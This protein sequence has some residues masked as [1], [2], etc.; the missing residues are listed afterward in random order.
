M[1]RILIIALSGIGDAL[2][3]TPALKLL[4]ES[5]PD[6]KI[7]AL[8][9][10]KG[11]KEM[12]ERNPHLDNV[13]YFDFINSG[14]YASLKFVLSL[15]LKYDAA[16]NVY[17]SNRKEY[18]VISFLT[19][20]RNRVAA[21]YLRKDFQNLGFLNNLRTVEDDS[22]HN[23]LTNVMLVESLLNKKFNEK[24][25]LDFPV[26]TEDENYAAKF[27]DDIN[28]KGNDIVIGFHPGSA[29]LKNHIHRR[30][31][32]EKFAEL[33]KRLINEF[34]ASVFIFGGPEEDELKLSIKKMIGLPLAYEIK[35]KTLPQSLGLIKRCN[36]FVT[37]DSGM[38]HV[39][40]ALK[41]NVVAL[42][43]PTNVNYI[44]P[45]NT[46]YKTVSLNLECSPCFFYSP[47]P[48]TC[49]RTDVKY[50]CIKELGV[51]AAYRAVVEFI[52]SQSV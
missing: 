26:T 29:T 36:V 16:I 5:L 20:A 47:R 39:A 10:F 35:T 38:M 27:L 24:P 45:W 13:I 17:P 18:N 12:Y 50:K 43:G 14:I 31:E 23:V 48:L 19:G 46:N 33:G 52:K 8:T 49:T 7:D 9:M 4:R 41:R 6:A 21:K 34:G 25:D 22:R 15:R 30:W 42:I 3:F 28:I 37:N 40:S 2:M 32:P 1:K 44:H 11:A 51:D